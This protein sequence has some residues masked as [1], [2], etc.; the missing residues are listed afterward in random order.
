VAL[1]R[2]REKLKQLLEIRLALA[3]SNQEQG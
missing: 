1:H 3:E 2:V